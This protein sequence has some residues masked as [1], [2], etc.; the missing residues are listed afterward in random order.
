MS[1]QWL[2][3][4]G[5]V[6]PAIIVWSPLRQSAAS[7]RTFVS[8]TMDLCIDVN[9]EVHGQTDVVASC[10]LASIIIEQATTRL[11]RFGLVSGQRVA[12]HSNHFNK[13]TYFEVNGK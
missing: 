3:R 5:R 2:C 1:R 10:T 13:I 7:S 9:T 11:C 4:L 12:C 6:L 8:Q